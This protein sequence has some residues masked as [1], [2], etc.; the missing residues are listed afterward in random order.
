MIIPYLLSFLLL[1]DKIHDIHLNECN[2]FLIELNQSISISEIFH[3]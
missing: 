1:R 3:W 2:L